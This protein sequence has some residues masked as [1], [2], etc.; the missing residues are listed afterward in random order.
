MCK[1]LAEKI[2]FGL[3]LL[4]VIRSTLKLKKSQWGAIKNNLNLFK[5]FCV[6]FNLHSV[7]SSRSDGGVPIAETFWEF[8]VC[9][10]DMTSVKMS[11]S[12]VWRMYIWNLKFQSYF[13]QNMCVTRNRNWFF[14][15]AETNISST[16][17][18][19]WVRPASQ[20][21]TCL[22][23]GSWTLAQPV[24]EHKSDFLSHGPRIATWTTQM[25]RISASSTSE[26]STR[27]GDDVQSRECGK[28]LKF[29]ILQKFSSHLYSIYLHNS[30]RSHP[31]ILFTLHAASAMCL[32]SFL[33]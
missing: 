20:I 30:T 1:Y 8:W 29:P 6:V 10:Y 17:A 18:S 11:C 26:I 16:S 12:V 5:R 19:S 22:N 33:E 24:L 23:K 14:L 9:T 2:F 4:V 3:L 28:S 31:P 25:W 21:I 15:V 27:L 7:K 32:V 13:R